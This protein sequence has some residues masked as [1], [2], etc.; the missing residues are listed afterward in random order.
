MRISC[1]CGHTELLS[2]KMENFEVHLIRFFID[3]KTGVI[4]VV[5]KNCG[6]KSEEVLIGA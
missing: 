6:H 4:S 3:S 1:R 2:N 5:C